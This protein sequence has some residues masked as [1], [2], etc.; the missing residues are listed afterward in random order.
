VV[1]AS[2]CRQ[3]ARLPRVAP[4]RAAFLMLG[5]TCS[6]Y[7][8]LA[9]L[10]CRKVAVKH[11][12]GMEALEQLAYKIVLLDE[13]DLA[14]MGICSLIL[15]F[16]VGFIKKRDVNKAIS[17]S[18]YFVFM[19]LVY[20]TSNSV[21][22][23]WLLS[24]PAVE[25]GVLW[26]VVFSVFLSL[27]VIGYFTAIACIYR[28]RDAFE[29]PRNAWF[30]LVPLLNFYLLLSPSKRASENRIRFTPIVQGGT[31]VFVG[32][33]IFMLSAV[34]AAYVE[35]AVKEAEK[36][37]AS[38][39]YM[40]EWANEVKVNSNLPQQYENGLIWEDVY[41]LGGMNVLV[42]K[43]IGIPDRNTVQTDVDQFWGNGE[44]EMI[45]TVGYSDMLFLYIEDSSRLELGV[46]SPRHGRWFSNMF[47][48]ARFVD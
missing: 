7:I 45:K 32:L 48:Y 12:V 14:L 19:G 35:S 38:D 15:G 13:S 6:K 8:F 39:Q 5:V 18:P 44:G 34:P 43:Y 20:F 4:L 25:I 11:A 28:S 41:H 40:T 17:R 9:E 22:L 29:T 37:S 27:A 31:G 24:E 33:I 36:Y 21:A 47:E 26:I 23:L 10:S 30:G 46:Y 16:V 1:G 3:A 2:P 42:Y